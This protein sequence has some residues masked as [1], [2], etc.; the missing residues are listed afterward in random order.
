M[1]VVVAF[2]LFMGFSIGNAAQL[3]APGQTE[4]AR[5][6]AVTVSSG[7]GARAVV[8]N[9][10]DVDKD[11]NSAPCQV[12]VKFF[13]PDGSLVGDATTLRLK[14]GESRSVAASQPSQLLRAAV[15]IDA[16]F[17]SA[18]VCDLKARVEIFDLQTGT[19]FISVAADPL[20]VAGE[21]SIISAAEHKSS[22]RKPAPV[23][24]TPAALPKR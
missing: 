7:Q 14:A 22:R 1:R 5:F 6:A 13:D 16:G 2:V 23:A 20:D 8:S 18:K 3:P 10:I 15:S 9:V 12:Q 11:V 17:D 19:T 24:L 21:C 4:L